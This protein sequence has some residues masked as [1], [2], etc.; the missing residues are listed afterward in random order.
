LALSKRARFLAF[1]LRR[2]K[3]KQRLSDFETGLKLV[4]LDHRNGPA[5]PSRWLRRNC[6]IEETVVDDRKVYRL[7]PKQG[8][9]E[10]HIFYL[11]GGG[12]AF[13]IAIVHWWLI[14]KMIKATGA[15]VTVP[16]YPLAPDHDWSTSYPFVMQAFDAAATKYG[17][18]NITIM[19][20]SAGGGYSMSASQLLRDQGK[21]MPGKIILLSPWLDVTASDPRPLEMDTHDVFR[22][23]PGARFAGQFWA[24]DGND[25]TEFPVS[26]LFAPLSGLPPITVFS[27]NHD[28]LY[29]DALR[30]EAKAKDAGI[31][32]QMHIGNEMQHVW[33][34]FPIREAKSAVQQIVDAILD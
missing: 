25:A 2:S 14:A 23:V 10:H 26:P 34:L 3:I 12:Y 32:L 11:H 6:V 33:M 24:G 29:A 27:G 18:Q 28:I 22:S 16:L 17:A 31:S 9:A 19:G 5:R 1:I 21:P 4:K 8:A 30:L 15:S 7:T 20:D 13:N